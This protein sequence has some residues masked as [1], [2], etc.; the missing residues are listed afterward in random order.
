M[1][2][3]ST[4]P[5]LAAVIRAWF[6]AGDRRELDTV[7]S[8][9]DPDVVLDLSQG[10]LGLGSYTG[11]AAVREF[12]ADWWGSY[13]EFENKPEE[14]IDLGNGVVLSISHQT[15]RP[16]GISGQVVRSD[17]YVFLFE[18]GALVRWTAYPDIDEGRAAAERLAEERE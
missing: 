7:M 13:E 1:S 11:Y 8:V 18:A 15:A 3:E 14:I 9:F 5:D 6:E 17:A 2:E 16:V 12:I 10:A 4:T